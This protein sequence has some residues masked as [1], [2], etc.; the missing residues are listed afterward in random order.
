M[1]NSLLLL[2][3]FCVYLGYS[4][5]P[6]TSEPFLQHGDHI[7]IKVSVDD[8]EPLDFIF[9]T[10]DGLTVLD[11]N[12]AQ[13]LNLDLKQIEYHESVQGLISGAII[14]HNKIEINGFLMEK[15]V[16]VYATSLA[17]LE[18][19]IGRN[20]DGIVG[21][22]LLRHHNVRLNYDTKTFEIYNLDS[23]PKT[24]EKIPFEFESSIPTIQAN[25][26]LNN[27]E[28]LAGSYY[29]NTGAGT[30]LDFNTPYARE[31]DIKGKTGDHYTYLIKGIGEKETNHSEGRV[32]SFE[33]G[34]FKF[35]NMP[36]GISESNQGLQGNKKVSGIIGNRVLRQFNITFDYPN[37]RIFFEKG[38]DYGTSIKVNC[39]GIDVQLS[40][41]K[42]K[43]LIHQVYE[44][45]Q[46]SEAGIKL[47]DELVSIDGQSAIELG[48]IG[49]EDMLKEPG[50]TVE[51]VIKGND[52][53]KKVSLALKELI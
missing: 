30:S 50:K 16:K 22:D 47:N 33:F 39:S 14:K 24:G 3:A 10:G 44:G 6:L 17:H 27:G 20:V 5:T 51:L 11:L 25:V 4:Q 12:V 29:V 32:T 1:K 26:T 21:W 34:S 13:D 37:K 41:D 8:S 40:E 36:I 38:Q 23:Y 31:N 48:L 18:I 42:S 53:E 19:S 2:F 52:G 43:V 35:E 7:F 28:K 49:V 46:A 9:D 45:T 15:N